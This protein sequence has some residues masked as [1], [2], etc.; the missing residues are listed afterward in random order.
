MIARRSVATAMSCRTSSIIRLVRAYGEVGASG[1]S[2]V[3]SKSSLIAYSEAED[4]KTT[5]GLPRLT[6]WSNSSS[7]FATLS[8]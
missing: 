5:R 1:S 2:S 8:R 6:S 7:D 3:T 4:E